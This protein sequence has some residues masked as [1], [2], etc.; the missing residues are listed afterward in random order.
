M[1]SKGV[2]SKIESEDCDTEVD[3]E[4]WFKTTPRQQPSVGSCNDDNVDDDDGDGGGDRRIKFETG[5]K[6]SFL[7]KM[8][9]A[10]RV[11]ALEEP[12]R[13]AIIKIVR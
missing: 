6:D 5:S 12:P 8:R 7:S 13:S 2:L 10:T 9:A 4:L 11:K 3:D 1:V